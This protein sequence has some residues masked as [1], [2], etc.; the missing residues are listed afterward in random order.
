MRALSM[1]ITSDATP[2]WG[3]DRQRRAQESGWCPSGRAGWA[4]PDSPDDNKL[5]QRLA[6]ACCT[7]LHSDAEL[8]YATADA[9]D[10]RT[11]QTQ[12]AGVGQKTVPGESIWARTAGVMNEL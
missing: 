3:A 11:L 10:D 12:R 6:P 7:A 1:G 9:W 5:V 2:P 4:S 8:A